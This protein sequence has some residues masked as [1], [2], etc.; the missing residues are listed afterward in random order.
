MLNVICSLFTVHSK[1][2]TEF[3]NNYELITHNQS[4]FAPIALVVLLLFGVAAGVILVQ[5][6]VNFLPKAAGPGDWDWPFIC[7]PTDIGTQDGSDCKPENQIKILSHCNGTEIDPDK[8]LEYYTNGGRDY[9]CKWNTACSTSL[10]AAQPASTSYSTLKS[11][12]SALP[13]DVGVSIRLPSGETITKNSKKPLPSYSVIKL[14][15]AAYFIENGLYDENKSEIDNMLIRSNNNATNSLI[16]KSGGVN[17]INSYI[18]GKGYSNTQLRRKMEVI[19]TSPSNDNL[20]SANDAYM[21][22]KR[23]ND[24]DINVSTGIK[25]ILGRRTTSKSDIFMPNPPQVLSEGSGFYGKS[26]ILGEGRNDVGSFLNSKGERVYFALLF[27]SGGPTSANKITEIERLLYEAG[28]PAVAPAAAK[29]AAA[30]AQ[31][32]TQ[33]QAAGAPAAGTNTAP[34]L[35]T[36]ATSADCGYEYNGT[37]IPCYRIGVFDDKTRAQIVENAKIASQN[38]ILYEKVL[39]EIGG[40]M[41]AAA[42]KKAEEALQNAKNAA[43]CINGA[44]T[45][46]AT[47]TATT[48]TSTSSISSLVPC[49]GAGSTCSLT[50]KTCHLTRIDYKWYCVD[51]GVFNKDFY[52]G[53]ISEEFSN[54]CPSSYPTCDKYGQC[55]NSANAILPGTPNQ[56]Q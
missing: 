28:V 24:V 21:F 6:G 42:K 1:K 29:P 56:I 39:S 11:T 32:A 38:Y 13:N 22:I 23:L 48:T 5:N 9:Y 40:L 10:T 43:A 41:D 7:S 17:A 37:R 44:S 19:P 49:E 20:T 46:P 25:D 31:P 4:G 53:D 15:I 52:C 16:D 27:P 8:C 26:G 34:G 33:R 50:T 36:A 12:I 54:K 45:T 51:K 14:W 35:N 30:P 47:T 3:P 18:A 55:R 2:Q